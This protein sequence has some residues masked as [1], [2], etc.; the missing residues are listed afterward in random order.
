MIDKSGA[1]TCQNGREESF[2]ICKFPKKKRR[3]GQDQDSKKDVIR[4]GGTS[5]ERN[6]RQQANQIFMNLK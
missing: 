4:T 1:P 3:E 6:N 5:K 2:F